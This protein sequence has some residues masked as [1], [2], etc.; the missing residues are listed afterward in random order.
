MVEKG[1]LIEYLLT[2]R[3]GKQE[4][5]TNK[6]EFFS[7]FFLSLIYTFCETLPWHNMKRDSV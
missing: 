6:W 5:T 7:K 4:R 3:N 2:C 1:T